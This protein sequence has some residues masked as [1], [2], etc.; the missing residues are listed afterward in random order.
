MLPRAA[1]LR[2]WKVERGTWKVGATLHLNITPQ[3]HISPSTFHVL[4]AAG[5]TL[6]LTKV[7]LYVQL[8]VCYQLIIPLLSK[9]PD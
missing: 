3:E 9:S 4:R 6:H 2:P 7:L 1:G 5:A 8:A